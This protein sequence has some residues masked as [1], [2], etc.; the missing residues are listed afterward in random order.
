MQNSLISLVTCTES[1]GNL[2][3]NRLFLDYESA[4][5]ALKTEYEGFMKT[6]LEDVP[7]EQITG[8]RL[9]DR[10]WITWVE[11][12]TAITYHYVINQEMIE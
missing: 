12:E 1:S 5:K 6:L 11:G 9:G 7:E 10:A 3:F 4:V 8:Q 2:V